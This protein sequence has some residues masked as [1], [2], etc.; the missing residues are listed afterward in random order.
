MA[1]WHIGKDGQ[2]KI[3][4][5]SSPSSC[6]LGGAG[7]EVPHFGSYTDAMEYV[8]KSEKAK[9]YQ[10]ATKLTKASSEGGLFKRFRTSL[11][12]A[13]I[14]KDAMKLY[15]DRLHWNMDRGDDYATAAAKASL[16]LQRS[17]DELVSKY[18]SAAEYRAAVKNDPKRRRNDATIYTALQL[19]RSDVK[20]L[21]LRGDLKNMI[22]TL[23]SDAA[24]ADYTARLDDLVANHETIQVDMDDWRSQELLSDSMKELASN[25][26]RKL[27]E[28]R[29]DL[30]MD[31]TP[32]IR[33]RKFFKENQEARLAEDLTD[34]QNA[35]KGVTTQ[36]D[37]DALPMEKQLAAKMAYRNYATDLNQ[38]ADQD[39]RTVRKL[40][41]YNRNATA[42]NEHNITFQ[43]TM[44]DMLGAYA[45][46]PKVDMCSWE[47]QHLSTPA[48][49]S[50]DR[51]KIDMFNVS[52]KAYQTTRAMTGVMLF[53]P[54]TSANKMMPT[55]SRK[56]AK[57]NARWKQN[58]MAAAGEMADS[59]DY[60]SGW[61]SN[62]ANL[63]ALGSKHLYRDAAL[64]GIKE[65]L[66]RK[67]R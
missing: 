67:K 64:L 34:V 24:K 13:S 63:F 56:Q 36:E 58:R 35:L 14:Q 4:K 6:P 50:A 62:C 10:S 40:N 39:N 49:R 15:T 41:D 37:W 16:D 7:V 22:N 1:R 46:L 48:M 52:R 32:D 29:V 42:L 55:N 12:Q 33:T 17:S 65:S 26:A 11:Q 19:A 66:S 5:A 57:A 30:A 28:F 44:G 23:P 43:K 61:G 54:A 59:K 18:G 3:C 51:N 8:E 27:N 47:Y 45:Q 20:E 21:E 53:F 2:P 25:S 31:S 9:A 38:Y 60:L